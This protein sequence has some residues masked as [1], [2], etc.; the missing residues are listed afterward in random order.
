MQNVNAQI[1]SA[2]I[3]AVIIRADGTRVN[4]GTIAYYHRNP[5]KR[6]IYWLKTRIKRG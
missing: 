2:E 4:L 5:L 1:E 6:L 3:E